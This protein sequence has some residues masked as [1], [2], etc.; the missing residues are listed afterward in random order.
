[1]DARKVAPLVC[2]FTSLLAGCLDSNFGPTLYRPEI[3]PER[4]KPETAVVQ[5]EPEPQPI[6][7]DEAELAAERVREYIAQVDTISQRAHRDLVTVSRAEDADPHELAHT[8]MPH[9]PPSVDVVNVVEPP[10]ERVDPPPPQAEPATPTATAVAP[11]PPEPV[12]A[13]V[14]AAVTA[15]EQSA[16][17]APEPS[18]SLE[19]PSPNA[20]TA[21]RHAPLSL[22]QFL[23]QWTGDPDDSSFRQ[24]L[25]LRI[26]RAIA[27]DYE[28]AREPLTMVSAEQQAMGS[29][30]IE[31][32]IA[33]REA[34]DGDP[35][36]AIADVLANIDS[37]REA[38]RP[39]SE[40]R[41][42]VVTLCREVRG[43]G[44]YAPLEPAT[45]LAG[46][47]AEF[48]LY[49]EV[50]NFVSRPEEDK[51]FHAKFE[52]RTAILNRAGETVLDIHD[53]DVVDRCRNRRT[54]CFIPRLVRL[55]GTLSP[56]EYVAK[57]TVVDKL[58]E[59]LA[60]NRASFRVVAR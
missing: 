9:R 41:I 59:K 43:F 26:L 2:A 32:L 17:A 3:K 12:S 38:L 55:P 37:L 30:L 57:V 24:Q 53:P 56:G 11:E 54:D 29:R 14:L 25:D 60:E 18:G 48:V 13:P 4:P 5:A 46:A 49:C 6:A 28:A 36:Q 35:V 58:G 21:A 44:D 31:S 10:A 51:F 33:I 8:A 40:L 52:M 1:M 22:T 50:Q 20:P 16:I 15:R 19:A 39:M 47:A 27:G 42:P 45:F 34:H 23:Q 7:P